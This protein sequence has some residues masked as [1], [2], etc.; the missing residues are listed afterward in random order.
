MNDNDGAKQATGAPLEQAALSWCIKMRGEVTEELQKEFDEWRKEPAHQRA[1]NRYSKVMHKA[2]IL[3]TS[4]G[5][6]PKRWL[7]AG[8]A[9]A[10]VILFAIAI[11]AGGTPFPGSGD[12]LSARA[13]EPLVTQRGE[14]RRFLLD[15]GSTATLDTDTKVEV[16][17]SPDSRFLR[18]AYGRARLDVAKDARPFRIAVG[19]GVVTTREAVVDISIRA[20]RR[21]VVELISGTAELKPAAS[22]EHPRSLSAAEA[23]EY[24]VDDRSI[25]GSARGSASSS[26]EWPSGWADHRSIR[27]DQLVSEANRYAE[28]PIV[29]DDPKVATRMVT[30]RFKI[31]D[32]EM[33]V[34]RIAELFDLAV[35]RRADGIHLRT[36]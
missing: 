18:L 35:D 21:V 16:S 24:G 15:D 36:R 2:E 28:I 25:R 27:L 9:A 22:A 14:I 33:F 30:G 32:T 7:M 23:I 5:R 19:E 13:A 34:S 17:I 1:Y 31:S 12:G 29:V 4:A 8:A 26:R 20:N 11:S 10:A 3:K 6:R